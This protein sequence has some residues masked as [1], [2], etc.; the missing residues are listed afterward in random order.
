MDWLRFLLGF[1]EINQNSWLAEIFESSMFSL[2]L[3]GG[4]FWWIVDQCF[5]S[6]VV[7]DYP[8]TEFFFAGLFVI[9]W[10]SFGFGF[11]VEFISFKFL[12]CVIGVS[13]AL[14][15]FFFY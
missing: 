8:K 1:G 15:G 10:S 7:F 5:A 14:E 9:E 12:I 13:E 4:L 6:G 2:F 11:L 3:F